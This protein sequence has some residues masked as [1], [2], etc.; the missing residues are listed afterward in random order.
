MAQPTQ[1]NQSNVQLWITEKEKSLLRNTF[2]DREDLLLAIRNLFF[3]F[4]L[5]EQEKLL[6]RSINNPEVHKLLRKMFL[7]ELQ[8][9]DPI[10]Q[11]ID[12]WMTVRMEDSGIWYQT[13]KA[14]EKLIQI[15]QTALNFLKDPSSNS[16]DLS[17]SNPESP[18]LAWE[19]IARNTFIAHTGIQLQAI[20]ALANS[21]EET[22]AEIKER[23]KK[24]SLK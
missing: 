3:G 21:K 5:D 17:V 18:D 8:K 6:I 12:L 13:F 22:Q 23:L 20:R 9:T 2:K 14:R 1:A 24:D 7:P 16:V 19:L 11:S 15:L 10:G 4:K